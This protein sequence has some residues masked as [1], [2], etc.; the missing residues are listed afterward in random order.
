M[1]TEVYIFCIILG[2][3]YGNISYVYLVLVDVLK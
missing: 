1:L 3:C 2:S